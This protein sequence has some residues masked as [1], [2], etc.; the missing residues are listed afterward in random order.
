MKP[1]RDEAPGGRIPEA[2]GSARTRP[3]CYPPRLHRHKSGLEHV[4]GP[5]AD[6]LDKVQARYRRAIRGEGEL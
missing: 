1:G 4:A 6:L 2:P 3:Q 5:L